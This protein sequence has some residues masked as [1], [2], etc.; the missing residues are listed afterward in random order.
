MFKQWSKTWENYTA[1]I[2]TF[3][4]IL[5]FGFSTDSVG[6]K[7]KMWQSLAV[8]LSAGS[9]AIL[10]YRYSMIL[11][12]GASKKKKETAIALLSLCAFLV[13]LGLVII[14]KK[15]HQ[16]LPMFAVVSSVLMFW[17]NLFSTN[18]LK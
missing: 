14:Y 17:I 9:L 7:K 18:K 8:L 2:A 16:H 3:L 12:N 15:Q 1:L 4:A 13:V 11:K 6:G 5:C 10:M